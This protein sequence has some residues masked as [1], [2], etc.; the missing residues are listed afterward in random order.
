MHSYAYTTAVFM[1]PLTR[2]IIMTQQ[3]HDYQNST[4]TPSLDYFYLQAQIIQGLHTRKLEST[5]N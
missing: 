3:Y 5:H 4:Q 2:T 1:I